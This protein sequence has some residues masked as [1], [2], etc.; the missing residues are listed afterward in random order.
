MNGESLTWVEEGRNR[1]RNRRSNRG[2]TLGNEMVLTIQVNQD[3]YI[4]MGT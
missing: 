2:I 3:L 4:K 1:D